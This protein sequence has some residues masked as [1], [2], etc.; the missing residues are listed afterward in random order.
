MGFIDVGERSKTRRVLH[1]CRG[2]RPGVT[3]SL[4]RLNAELRAWY[5]QH[6]V[7]DRCQLS[8][9]SI[10]AT[11]LGVFPMLSGAGIKGATV[12]S[13]LH[14]NEAISQIHSAAVR[15]GGE[16]VRANQDSW[17]GSKVRFYVLCRLSP[18]GPGVSIVWRS[19][20]SS[21]IPPRAWSTGGQ[22]DFTPQ[23]QTTTTVQ[24][25]RSRHWF[26]SL[27]Y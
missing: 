11:N 24:I 20:P 4:S 25:S 2:L 26:H 18:F 12:W 8:M 3:C 9:K 27:R 6:H 22:M 13:K 15:V 1:G 16:A 10:G 19:A 23:L 7:T 21:C 14:F 17:H 5:S